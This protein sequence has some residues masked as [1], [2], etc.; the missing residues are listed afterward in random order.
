MESRYAK[1]TGSAAALLDS[2]LS[3]GLDNVNRRLALE[4]TAEYS[5]L[6]QDPGHEPIA[7]DD[8]PESGH[9]NR[10][11]CGC[12]IDSDCPGWHAI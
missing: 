3:N 1:L 2:I 12:P 10:L 11:P 4:W 8:P 6:M 7:P 5:Q 9:Y